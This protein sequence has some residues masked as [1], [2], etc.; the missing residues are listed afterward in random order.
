MAGF[1]HARTRR[2]ASAMGLD[3]RKDAYNKGMCSPGSLVNNPVGKGS[4]EASFPLKGQVFFNLSNV[5][6]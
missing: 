4:L 6:K 3:T 2:K 1:N 5:A